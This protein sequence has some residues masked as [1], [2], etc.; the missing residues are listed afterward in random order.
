MSQRNDPKYYLSYFKST[1][2]PQP[3]IRCSRPGYYEHPEFGRLDAVCLLDLINI[4]EVLWKWDDYPLVWARTE[5][6][7]RQS[8]GKKKNKESSSEIDQTEIG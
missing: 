2:R 5:S 3:C 6:I 7:I 8:G 1:S 4:G